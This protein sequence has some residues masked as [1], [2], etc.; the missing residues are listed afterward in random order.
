MVNNV[1]LH[2]DTLADLE[3]AFSMLA[4]YR[5]TTVVGSLLLLVGATGFGGVSAAPSAPSSTF[6]VANIK[7]SDATLRAVEAQHVAPRHLRHKVGVSSIFSA[8]S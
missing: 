4:R 8:H 7:P 2:N 5:I 3:R 6:Y 1:S